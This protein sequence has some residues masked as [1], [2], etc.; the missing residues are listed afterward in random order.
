MQIY[1]LF[2]YVWEVGWK[3][4]DQIGLYTH[5]RKEVNSIQ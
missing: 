1:P 5:H 2:L 4:P 3:N